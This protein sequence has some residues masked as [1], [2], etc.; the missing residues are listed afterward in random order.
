VLSIKA[1]VRKNLESSGVV[2]E[3]TEDVIRFG[4][5]HRSTYK[6]V[7]FEGDSSGV[8]VGG[9]RNVIGLHCLRVRVEGYTCG[10]KNWIIAE[11][12]YSISAERRNAIRGHHRWNW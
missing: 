4:I 8:I 6:F 12:G 1:A 9:C 3:D 5:R 7:V 10:L 11:S 2:E